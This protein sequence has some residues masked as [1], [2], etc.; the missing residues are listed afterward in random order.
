[1]HYTAFQ[2]KEYREF[3]RFLGKFFAFIPFL[4]L[5]CADTAVP[6][7]LLVA[8]LP[9]NPIIVEAGAQ[10]GED[11][12]K[13]SLLWPKGMLYCFEPSPESYPSLVELSSKKSNVF[14]FQ[15]ALSNINGQMPFYLAGG[16]S[17]LLTPQD[18][19]NRDYFHVDL[20]RPIFV[21]V[22][23]LDT[24]L[25]QQGISKVDFLWFDMEGNE[26]NALKGAERHLPNISLIYTEVNIQKFWNHCVCYEELKNYLSS[27]GFKEIWREICPNWQGN[28]LFINTKIVSDE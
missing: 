20:E 21:E 1:M 8:I 12:E 10:F 19:F 3:M 2:E 24:W 9:E 27:Q 28:A 17:S 22:V 6:I 11:S 14:C 16:A 25:D 13:M 26:L 7:D 4:K 15:L 18:H 23:D 5:F